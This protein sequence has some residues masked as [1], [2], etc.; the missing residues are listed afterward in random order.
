M[1]N[2]LNHERVALTSAAP[3]HCAGAPVGPATQPPTAP[4]S[5]TPSGSRCLGR[6]HAHADM[7]KLLNWQL[8]WPQYD[9]LG[10]ADASAT[11]VYGSELATEVYRC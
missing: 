5:S 2:Q 1:T 4:A 9:K 7:L 3:V 6:V 8:A 11:K 10:P